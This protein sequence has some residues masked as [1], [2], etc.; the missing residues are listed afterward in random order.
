VRGV[1]N[2]IVDPHAG[3]TLVRSF[4]SLERWNGNRGPGMLNAR[5][6]M[7]RAI[8]LS[9]TSGVGC[10]A[11]ANTNHWMRGGAYGWQ[12]AEAG[13]I[14]ICWTNTMPNLPPWGGRE[15]RV[16][17]NPLIVAVPRAS[18]QVVLDV[19]MSQ[20]S[21]GAI[22]SY[23]LRGELLPVPGGFTRD[24]EL[25][26]D[27]AE[28]ERSQRPLPIGYWKG[29]GL[30]LMLDLM[31]AV[32]S[33]GNATC[34]IEPDSERETGL[35][36]IF[37]AINPSL[38]GPSEEAERVVDRAIQFLHSSAPVSEESV[39]YPGENIVKIRRTNLELGIP[40]NAG[41]WRTI[42]EL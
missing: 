27:P 21:Y 11:L 36:Q 32:L 42:Q 13:V 3:A 1:R 31:A 25:T 41:V 28:I 39:R 7:Q 9:R 10:V 12:A 23:R 35:S 2:G 26:R 40:V 20:F 29:S 8:E 15:P 30:A 34:D 5:H 18:G 22:E 6:C 16:G 33:G 4:G 37:I 14:G 19:A 24:G 38:L 17:N